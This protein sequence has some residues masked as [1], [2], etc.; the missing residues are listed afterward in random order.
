MRGPLRQWSGQTRVAL[1]PPGGDSVSGHMHVGG[2]ESHSVGL[3][4]ASCLLSHRH[5][6]DTRPGPSM[7]VPSTVPCSLPGG[8]HLTFISRNRSGR[9][10]PALC[11]VLEAAPFLLWLQTPCACMRACVCVISVLSLSPPT[12]PDKTIK[13]TWAYTFIS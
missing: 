6:T 5:S 4:A 8:F 10:N 12:Q 2:A 1:S 3:I 13:Y 7:R 11:L 9:D